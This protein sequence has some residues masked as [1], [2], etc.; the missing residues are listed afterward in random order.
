[1]DPQAF[2]ETRFIMSMTPEEYRLLMR[3]RDKMQFNFNHPSRGGLSIYDKRASRAT[4]SGRPA[5]RCRAGA[6]P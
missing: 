4:C 1:M 2:D 5:P 6:R 3:Y